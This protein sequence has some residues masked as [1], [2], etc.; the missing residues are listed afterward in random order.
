MSV[1]RQLMLVA[2]WLVQSVPSQAQA[3]APSLV[4]VTVR[5]T[6]TALTLPEGS[7]AIVRSWDADSLRLD[8]LGSAE[9]VA[10]S[11]SA[12]QKV[13]YRTGRANSA[14]KGAMIGAIVG[15]AS[16]LIADV[17]CAGD[18]GWDAMGCPP[19]GA[20]TLAGAATWGLVGALIGLVVKRDRWADATP[21]PFQ[22]TPALQDGRPAISMA[23]RF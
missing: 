23:W 22:V 8:P 21:I 2:A 20:A 7:Q 19:P 12:V 10:V 17:S 14:R 3:P 18:E 1:A 13:E 15:G 11:W 6:T 4:G 9:Y 16:G 5:V